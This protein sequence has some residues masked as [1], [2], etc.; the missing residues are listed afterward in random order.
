MTENAEYPSEG[1]GLSQF[2]KN[3]FFRGK[4]MT[5]RD[6]E[7]EQTYHVERLQTLTRS[8]HGSGIV[9]GL[10]IHSVADT[11]EGVDVTIGPGLALD[12]QGRPIVVEQVTT[13]SLPEPTTD[14]LHLFVQYDEVAVET[15]PVPDT[16]GA[17]DEESVPNRTVEVFEL[18]HRETPPERGAVSA[19]DLTDLEAAGEEP[20]ALARIIAEQYHESSQSER[21]ATVDPAVYLGGFE[22]SS[23]GRWQSTADG[24]RRSYVYTHE[25]LRRV[26]IDHLSD[27]DN[28][29][30]TPVPGEESPEDLATMSKRLGRM[31]AEFDDVSRERDALTRYV[32]RKTIKDQLRFFES[33]SDRLEPHCGEGCRLAR[34]IAER[35]REEFQV[36]IDSVD[37]YQRELETI[38]PQLIELG[39]LLERFVTERSLERY[40]KSV[41]RLKTTVESDPPLIELIEAHDQTCEAADSLEILVDVVPEA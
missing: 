36:S 23:D 6:M 33:L 4:L 25:M 29:H 22:R 19:F 1:G 9:S 34:E 39:D 24:P 7:A 2:E 21:A 12:G 35:S 41:S 14:D 16:D 31:E 28:P 17:V 40:L 10:E 20:A 30:Q 32:V 8:I 5:P 13:K 18:V 11:D 26:L 37:D 27:T 38:L 3:R 15:V